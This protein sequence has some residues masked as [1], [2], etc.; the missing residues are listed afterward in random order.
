VHHNQVS[1]PTKPVRIIVLLFAGVCAPTRAPT[2]PRTHAP[3][4]STTNL[5]QAL[6]QFSGEEGGVALWHTGVAG[7]SGQVGGGLPPQA[8]VRGC[9]EEGGSSSHETVG[10]FF[11][12]LGSALQTAQV[13]GVGLCIG[14]HSLDILPAM[15]GGGGGG[16]GDDAAVV[17]ASFMRP[18]VRAATRPAVNAPPGKW[19]ESPQCGGSP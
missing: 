10:V 16:G 2:H 15:W 18:A 12:L 9:S 19:V 6:V 8:G 7:F 14:K 17:C 1:H 4:H 5:C 13:A 11:K 3:T